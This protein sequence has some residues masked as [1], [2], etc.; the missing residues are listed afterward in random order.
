ML[1]GPDLEEV[2]ARRR[3][4]CAGSFIYSGGIGTLAD[5]EALAALRQRRTS[6]GV[7]VGKA[8]YEG[9]SRSPRRR[10]RSTAERYGERC[11]TSA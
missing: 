1:D 2:D 4:A 6:T 3:R 8:L 11:T 5:L 10:R 7:I 9:A